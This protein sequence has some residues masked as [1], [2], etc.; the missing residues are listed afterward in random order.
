M[1]P[2]FQIIVGCLIQCSV[3]QI[4]WTIREKKRGQ[5]EVMVGDKFD[6]FTD[7]GVGEHI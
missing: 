4:S 5:E 3:L 1:A 2:D 7:L 6:L